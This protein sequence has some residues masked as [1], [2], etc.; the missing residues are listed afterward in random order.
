M[1]TT[2]TNKCPICG[3]NCMEYDVCHRCNWENDPIQ[4]K[5]PDFQ[6]GANEMSLDEAREA[7]KNGEKIH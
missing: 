3:E 6:G 1:N 5:N 4:R 7:Y 2:E